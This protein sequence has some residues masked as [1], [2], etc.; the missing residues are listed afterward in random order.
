MRESVVDDYP[1][2]SRDNPTA[3]ERKSKFEDIA[4][5]PS[6]STLPNGTYTPNGCAPPYSAAHQRV[7][8]LFLAISRYR[9]HP[10]LRT[11]T[12]HHP[13]TIFLS[14]LSPAL[15][16]ST[17]QFSYEFDKGSSSNIL[18]RSQRRPRGRC[19]IYNQTS[20]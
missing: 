9:S 8:T 11:Q 3:I 4:Q 17:A 18:P 16:L 10:A 14:A 1:S 7:A 15:L 12:F 6:C 2:V 5:F 20:W 19:N 13:T